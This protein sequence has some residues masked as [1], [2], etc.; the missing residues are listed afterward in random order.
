MN[1]F[2]LIFDFNPFIPSAH[3]LFFVKTSENHKGF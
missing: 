3:F 2:A 1:T